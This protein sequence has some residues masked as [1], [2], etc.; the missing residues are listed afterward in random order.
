[1]EQ[2]TIILSVSVLIV[3]MVVLVLL[4]KVLQSQA[5]SKAELPLL[6]ENTNQILKDY[7]KNFSE[8]LQNVRME[9]VTSLHQFSQGMTSQ[10]QQNNQIQSEKFDRLNQT[11]ITNL[12]KVKEQVDKNL[13]QIQKD[14]NEK[15]EQMRIT[16]DE[17]LQASVEKRFNESFHL[18]SQRLDM[19]QQGLGEMQTLA[20][21]VGDL[22]KVLT[23][24]KTRGNLGEI[25]L[26]NI[27]DQV[28][29][30]AQYEENVSVKNPNERVEF[31]I[32]LPNNQASDQALLLPIDSKFPMED[33]HRLL[34]AYDRNEDID[35][36][37]RAFESAVKKNARDISRKY[38]NPP[39]TTD[40]AIMFVPTEGLYAEIL[41]IP[42]L[43]E[44]LQR[45][46]KITVVGP[47]NLVAFL[48]SLQ[49]GF[50][51]LAIEK[52][53]SEVWELLATIK[54]EFHKF[55]TVL[56]QTKKKLQEASNV[57]DRASTRTRVIERKLSNVESLEIKEQDD[58][59]EDMSDL[60]DSDSESDVLSE[61]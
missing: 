41:R 45:D 26:K 17:K 51:T 42:G 50:R 27:L 46:F 33:F 54:N 28:L 5:Q 29:T 31:A 35:V 36:T 32:K 39:V 9:T 59:I 55:G 23:N 24:V 4:Y 43:F 22:K 21:G 3:L 12:D 60:L 56:D 52:R 2:L 47:A 40:F 30:H 34:D 57:I 8:S 25:Q 20:T 15:L 19:V 37:K 49:M 16:V 18:I 7:N 10:I 11:V 48:S 38:I 14:N 53:S 61:I 6:Q 13:S 1:M 44:V 58:A